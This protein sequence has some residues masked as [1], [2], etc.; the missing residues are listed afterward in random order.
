MSDCNYCRILWTYF[1]KNIKYV[2]KPVQFAE[3][4]FFP[5]TILDGETDRHKSSNIMFL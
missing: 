5:K 4:Y 2:I 1:E 3:E